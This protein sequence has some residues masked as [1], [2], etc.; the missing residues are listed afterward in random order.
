MFL[1]NLCTNDI[2]NLG[3]GFGCEAFLTTAK[4]RVVAQFFVSRLADELLRLDTVAGAGETLCKHLD[5]YL[6][7]EQ[8]EIADRSDELGQ[9]LLC[10]PDA[11]SILTKAGAERIA[12]LKHLQH[13]EV[14]VGG[15]TC[16]VRRNDFINVPGFDLFCPRQSVASVWWAITNGGAKPAG[17]QAFDTLRIEAGFPLFGQDIDDNRLVMEVGRTAQAICYT[18]GCFLGQEPIV[19][20][21]DRGHVN[22]GLMGLVVPGGAVVPEA[23]KVLCDGQEVGQVTS[24]AYSPGLQAGIALAYLKRGSQTPGS[25]VDIETGEGI[26]KAV[27]AAVPLEM[28]G[29]AVP[30]P[31]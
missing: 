17:W 13:V 6:I 18:K 9:L 28:P 24:S 22:R 26:G 31:S 5:H 16:L 10:G 11:G 7:S 29:A 27:I 4:A 2:K 12:E 15:E 19:M 3:P 23:A 20:A 8:V 21:R 14:S 25:E 1:H 30:A